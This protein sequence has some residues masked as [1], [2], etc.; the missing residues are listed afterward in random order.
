FVLIAVASFLAVGACVLPLRRGRLLG[1][2]DWRPLVIVGVASYSL[3]IW[4]N[5]IVIWLAGRSWLPHV[6]RWQILIA[7]VVCVA[8]ALASYR[9]IE[10]PFLRLRRQWSPASARATAPAVAPTAETATA[11][12]APAPAHETIESAGAVTRP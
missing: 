8:V 9:L 5:P 1:A 6:Y 11:A 2:L 4:H 10:A 3:Y 7:G 12:A